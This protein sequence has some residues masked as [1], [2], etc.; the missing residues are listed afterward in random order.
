ML[1]DGQLK[2]VEMMADVFPIALSAVLNAVYIPVEESA[3]ENT[4]GIRYL[5][6][7]RKVR[8]WI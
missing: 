1:N 3:L 7:K 4:F 8:R 2:T 5:Q 6:Y